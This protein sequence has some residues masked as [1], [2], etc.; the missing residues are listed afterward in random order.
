MQAGKQMSD[1]LVSILEKKLHNYLDDLEALVRINSGTAHKAGVDQVVDW[2][3]NR[4]N[5]LGFEIERLPQTKT[6]DNLLAALDGNGSGTILLLGHS[7]TVYPVGTTA[8]RPLKI[9]G[10][11]I[12]G[13][14]T[15][16]MKAGLL[17]GC[18]AVE[19]LSELGFFLISGALFCCAFQMKRF[20]S[21][22]PMI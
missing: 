13:P 10:D 17:S 16:D 8:E 15:C 6:G 4:L 14:G 9:E 3:E 12:L 1:P 21:V 20:R 22:I 7:D 5:N 2:M 19:A 11:K 18:Y